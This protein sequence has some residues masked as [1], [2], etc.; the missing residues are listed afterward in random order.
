MFLADVAIKHITKDGDF[1]L[2]YVSLPEGIIESSVSLKEL[3]I[4]GV[5]FPISNSA[6]RR[7][8]VPCR[9]RRHGLHT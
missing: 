3:A 8:A 2:R 1:P 5:G 7:R 6:W 4:L 9:A